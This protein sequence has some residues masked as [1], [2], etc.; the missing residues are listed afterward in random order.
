[1]ATEQESAVLTERIE[2][3]LRGDDVEAAVE[4]LNSTHPAD[5]ADLYDR[6][7]ETDRERMLALLSAEGIAHLLEHM[8]E[9]LLK[10]VVDGMPRSSLAR[11]LDLTDHDIAADV[12]RMLPP[13]DAA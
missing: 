7:D 9:E 3:L 12:L 4:L 10:E 11:V 2:E 5:Q 6:L 13:S 8:E 1:M